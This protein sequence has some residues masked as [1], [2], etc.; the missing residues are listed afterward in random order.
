MRSTGSLQWL[1]PLQ[2]TGYTTQAQQLWPTSLLPP[3]HTASSWT[4][5]R[6]CVSC[7]GGWIFNHWTTREILGGWF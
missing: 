5:G 1:L 6:T 3:R 4:S 2:S 7:I